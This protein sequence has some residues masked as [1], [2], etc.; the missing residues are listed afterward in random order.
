MWGKE[1]CI[2]SPFS[3]SPL[4]SCQVQLTTELSTAT[5]QLS[6]LQME[7]TGSRH[8]EAEL[9]TQLASSVAESQKS[10]GNWASLKQTHDGREGGRGSDGREG[11]I[12]YDGREGGRA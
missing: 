11:G 12:G 5:A 9:K 7:L 4:S 3:L 6:S 10:A 2:I 1:E 8:R